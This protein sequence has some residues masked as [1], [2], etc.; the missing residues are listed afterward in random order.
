MSG[1]GTVRRDADGAGVRF[2]RTY[3]AAPAEL[4]RAWTEPG[5]IARW[6]GAR[7]V[8]GPVEPGGSFT[9][10]WGEEPDARVRVVVR[11]LLEP[12]LLE[13]VW[14]IAGEPPTVLRVELSPA[15]GGRT[16]LLLD[17]GRLPGDQV[18]GLS[19]GWEA[20]LDALAVGDAG[21]RDERFA[22]LLP[23]YRERVAA[24]G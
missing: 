5:R 16:R 6:L 9:L 21:G 17:H 2:E 7:V 22:A 1:Y 11:E 24:L 18:A 13:W 23:V 12:E 19:A 8:G 15:P 14:T 10:V 4:W 20:Y 3:E